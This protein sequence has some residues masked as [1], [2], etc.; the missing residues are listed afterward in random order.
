MAKSIEDLERER[1][2]AVD[3]AALLEEQLADLRFDTQ[4]H[5]T[6]LR[7]LLNAALQADQ[8]SEDAQLKILVG[9]LVR[10]YTDKVM[11]AD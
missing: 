5:E 8:R 11:R 9:R 1:N 4:A 6:E 10:Q 7:T 3:R 2:D